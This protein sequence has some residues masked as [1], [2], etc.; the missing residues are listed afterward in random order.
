MPPV[1]YARLPVF[2]TENSEWRLVA[3]KALAG[4][5]G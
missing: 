5:M 4:A 3:L 1:A 2:E